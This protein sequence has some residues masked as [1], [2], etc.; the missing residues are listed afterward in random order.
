MTGESFTIG[1]LSR[2]TGCN[3]STIRYYEATGLMSPAQRTSAGHRRYNDDDLRD[4]GLI[5][6][7]RSLGF[8]TEAIQK[9]LPQGRHPDEGCSEVDAI[10]TE[11]LRRIDEEIKALLSFRAHLHLM[12]ADCVKTTVDDCKVINGLVTGGTIG[13]DQLAP[14][15]APAARPGTR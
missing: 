12:L 3:V 15:S 13:R 10:A 7:A 6:A 11:H 8:G 2:L 9:L 14:E 5:R 1:E 4:L